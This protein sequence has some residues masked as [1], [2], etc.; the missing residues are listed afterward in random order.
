MR[1]YQFLLV[2]VL[3]LELIVVG[4]VVEIVGVGG[5]NFN[6]LHTKLFT[7][8]GVVRYRYWGNAFYLRCLIKNDVLEAS[9][10]FRNH[11]E[12]VDDRSLG[13]SDISGDMKSY[14]RLRYYLDYCNPDFSLDD[15][16]SKLVVILNEEFCFEDG[17]FVSGV[18]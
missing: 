6:R 10:V 8:F 13:H 7:G 11:N 15:L 16:K 18:I 3:A 14:R 9:W 17:G 4:V 2:L 1:Q 12:F 5:W